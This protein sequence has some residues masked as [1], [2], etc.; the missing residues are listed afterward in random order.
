[1]LQGGG[2]GGIAMIMTI[3]LRPKA[4]MLGL[5][6]RRSTSL[7]GGPACRKYR[8]ADHAGLR[9]LSLFSFQ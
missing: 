6:T 5:N 3:A 8:V 7:L 1:M 9:L 4:E 2:T